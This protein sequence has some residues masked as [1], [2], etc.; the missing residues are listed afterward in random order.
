[1]PEGHAQGTVIGLASGSRSEDVLMAAERP[2]I[3]PARAKAEEARI[4]Q[5]YARRKQSVAASLYSYFNSGT[6]LLEQELE[7]HLLS[8]LWRFARTALDDQLGRE[9]LCDK[10][11][12]EVGC[13]YGARLQNLV[14]WGASP[15]KLFGLDL[16]PARIAQARHLLPACVTVSTGDA[17][18]LAF[19]NESFDLVFQFTVFSSI[20]DHE[21][22]KAAAREMLRVV[23]A[24]GCI[25]WYDFYVNN[26][27]NR[28]ARG[29]KRTEVRELFPNCRYHFDRVT[30]APP[31]ARALAP[32]SAVL[33]RLLS[34]AKLFS[35]HDLAFITKTE[36][37]AQACTP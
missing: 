21:V 7:R 9:P 18:E 3:E 6:L 4:M 17:T 35:T 5:A 19:A 1:M 16:Q 32:H 37:Q 30:L 13:G 29:V 25:V 12:L 11:I 36:A 20:L 27:R 31:V 8:G 2:K 34:S 28:D 24:S 15:E 10:D 33:C 26:P 14:R 22:R 23:K